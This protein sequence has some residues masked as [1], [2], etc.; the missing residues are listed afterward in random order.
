MM[1]NNSI[2]MLPYS[3][4]CGAG[5][6]KQYFPNI[7]VVLH[8]FMRLCSHVKREHTVDIDMQDARGKE[9]EAGTEL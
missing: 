9:G 3:T 4:Q 6:C 8:S 5:P 1:H 7:Q 2:V